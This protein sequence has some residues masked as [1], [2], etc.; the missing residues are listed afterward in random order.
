MKERKYNMR[1]K[2]R[3][4]YVNQITKLKVNYIK[5]SKYINL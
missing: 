4:E 3:I 2:E 1:T 5:N